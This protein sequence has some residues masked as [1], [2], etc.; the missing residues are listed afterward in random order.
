MVNELRPGLNKTFVVPDDP[1][2]G[3]NC[4]IVV[5]P[6]QLPLDSTVKF[7]APT[8]NIGLLLND[9]ELGVTVIESSVGVDHSK[10]SYFKHLF[11]QSGSPSGT[12]IF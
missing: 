6:V 2:F 10:S 8:T 12:I 9:S 1:E 5:L 3:V 4:P 11:V 7:V